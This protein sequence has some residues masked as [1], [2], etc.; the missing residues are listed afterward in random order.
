MPKAQSVA[1]CSFMVLFS[2]S[3]DEAEHCPCR[4]PIGWRLTENRAMLIYN[5]RSC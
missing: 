5:E 3:V 1:A 4:K 2:A